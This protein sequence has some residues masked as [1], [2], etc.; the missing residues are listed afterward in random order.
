MILRFRE[1]DRATFNDIREGRKRVETRAATVKYRNIAPG[2]TIVFVCGSDRFE[3]TVNTVEHFAS[4][5][6]LLKK[7]AVQDINAAAAT[8]HELK[9]MYD[10][11]PGYSEK[12]TEFGLLAMTLE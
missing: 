8:P 3:R 10:G 1:V 5:D 2:D 4:V 12:I 6:D 7:H 11:F 9:A